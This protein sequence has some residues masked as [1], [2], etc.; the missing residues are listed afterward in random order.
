MKE[1]WVYCHLSLGMRQ[2][3]ANAS[4]TLLLMPIVSSIL[5]SEILWFEQFLGANICQYE[6]LLGE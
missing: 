1:S 5:L 2:T 6:I 4:C 3:L